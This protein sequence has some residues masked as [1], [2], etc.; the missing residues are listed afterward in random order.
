MDPVL[1]WSK[2]CAA[3]NGTTECRV[4]FS[5]MCWFYG[6]D[7]FAAL[8]AT[9]SPRP[10]GL[11]GTYWGGTADELWSSTEAL[12]KCPTATASTLRKGKPPAKSNSE[13]WHG[14]VVPLLKT[15]IKGAI[16][17]TLDL[18]LIA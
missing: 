10:I 5:N 3:G 2:P 4:D 16:W 13:L 14:M 1:G 8:E 17:C 12:A 11:I 7:V 15:T 9:G 6:R 18:G